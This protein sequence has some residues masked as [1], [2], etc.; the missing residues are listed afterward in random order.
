VRAG[1]AA[2]L[3]LAAADDASDLELGE[4]VVEAQVQDAPFAVGEVMQ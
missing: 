3:H 1:D 4:V 2:D